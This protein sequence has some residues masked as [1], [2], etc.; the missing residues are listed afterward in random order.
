MVLEFTCRSHR[1]L[2]ESLKLPVPIPSATLS[3][4]CAYRRTGAA[5]LGHNAKNLLFRKIRCCAAAIDCQFVGLDPHLQ[6]A[7]VFHSCLSVPP[8]IASSAAGYSKMHTA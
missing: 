2:K 7:E 8:T 3:D 5:D 6:I 4:I 1:Y